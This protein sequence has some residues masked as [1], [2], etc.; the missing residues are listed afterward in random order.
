[1]IPLSEVKSG[2]RVKIVN[3]RSGYGFNRK[4]A[5]MGIY[6]GAV[7]DVI[8]NAGYGP[9]ILSIKGIRFGVGF[10]M[11]KKIFVDKDFKDHSD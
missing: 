9:V 2:S 1:M 5:D 4:M 8:R 6:P 11:A 10:G 7:V 3:I